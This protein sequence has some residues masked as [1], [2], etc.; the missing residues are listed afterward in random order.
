MFLT[1]STTGTDADT[2]T[3]SVRDTTTRSLSEIRF[4]I[5]FPCPPPPRC[6]S[7]N[8]ISYPRSVSA[9]A[10]ASWFAACTKPAWIDPSGAPTRYLNVG[11]MLR[12]AEQFLHLCDGF[13]RQRMRFDD[14]SCGPKLHATFNIFALPKVGQHKHGN[15]LRRRILLQ[16]FEDFKPIQLWHH[17]IQ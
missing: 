4:K 14:I 3:E 6:S 1:A 9:S 15:I 13:V 5:P 8:K 10:A 2:I 17:Q 16:P 7:S 11:M 12:L